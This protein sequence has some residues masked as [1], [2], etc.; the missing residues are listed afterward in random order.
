MYIKPI[1]LFWLSN[2]VF[3]FL[4]ISLVGFISSEILFL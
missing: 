1:K 2:L 4:I 3:F